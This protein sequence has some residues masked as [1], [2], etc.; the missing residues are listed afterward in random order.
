M[1][2]RFFITALLIIMSYSCTDM[3]KLTHDDKDWLLA[4]YKSLNYLENDNNNII[5]IINYHFGNIQA[6]IFTHN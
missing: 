1:K 2:T 6:K 4:D 3:C 5:V